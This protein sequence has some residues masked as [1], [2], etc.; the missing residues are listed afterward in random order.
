MS[1]TRKV[2]YLKQ[3]E[4][5]AEFTCDGDV[6]IGDIGEHAIV[7]INGNVTVLGNIGH[8]A[9]VHLGQ[10]HADPYGCDS[11]ESFIN[12]EA[13]MLGDNLLRLEVFGQIDHYVTITGIS[14]NIHSFGKVGTNCNVS[15]NFGSIN[16]FKVGANAQLKIIS[17]NINAGYITGNAVLETGHGN[18]NVVGV[19]D[20]NVDLLTKN[21]RVSVETVHAGAHLT[22]SK[23]PSSA[24]FIAGSEVK[25]APKA[26]AAA[27]PY[28]P[29]LCGS[30]PLF[31]TNG[32]DKRTIPMDRGNGNDNTSSLIHSLTNRSN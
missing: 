7:K 4:P 31:R 16:M 30:H 29:I 20:A 32:M 11:S 17:G 28:S 3:I 1:M 19:L 9:E 24:L 13:V 25:T 2:K 5:H 21:G 18:I 26:E 6:E 27:A 8:H 22:V 12:G 15:T 23:E 10:N 14:A